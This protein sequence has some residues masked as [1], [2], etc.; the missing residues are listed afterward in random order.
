MVAKDVYNIAKALSKKELHTLYY[1][2]KSDINLENTNFKVRKK[3]PDYTME[4]GLRYLLE[5]HLKK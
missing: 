1:M 4:D 5:N 3:T 2:L